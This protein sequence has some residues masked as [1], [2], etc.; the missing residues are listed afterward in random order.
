MTT[1]SSQHSAGSDSNADAGPSAQIPQLEVQSAAQP[2]ENATLVQFVLL[3]LLRQIEHQYRPGLRLPPIHQIAA[4]FDVSVGTANQAIKELVSRGVVTSRPRLGTTLA[5]GCDREHI[6]RILAATKD[7]SRHSANATSG[8]QV[9]VL[10]RPQAEAMLLE[11]S[12]C[13]ARAMTS[14]GCKVKFDDIPNKRDQWVDAAGQDGTVIFQPDGARVPITW[15]GDSPLLVV[16]TNR[17]YVT[18]SNCYDILAIDDEQGSAL[19]GEWMQQLCGSAC[20]VGGAHG[21]SVPRQLDETSRRRLA[22]FECGWGDTLTPE[23]RLVAGSYDIASGSSVVAKYIALSPRPEGV[24]C[25]SDDLAIGFTIGTRA[26][27]LH[28]GQDYQLIGFDKQQ[29]AIEAPDGPISTIEIPRQIMGERAAELLASRLK[30]P[31]QPVRRVYLGC[32][33][34]VGATTKSVSS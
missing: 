5:N 8:R 24:F 17:H 20:F 4:E 32:K 7:A 15:A 26:H 12:E 33:R 11:I 29:R 23:T 30:D 14:Y 3:Q 22:A 2:E 27:G 25:A 13:F 28:A 1:S 9:S 18:G 34:F 21:K 31:G 10:I 16:A 6:S 19:A